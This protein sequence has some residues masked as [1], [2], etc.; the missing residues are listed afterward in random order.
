[1]EGLSQNLILLGLL[2]LIGVSA[3]IIGRRTA[4]PRVSILL[5]AGCA[6]GPTGLDLVPELQARWF[7]WVTNI[8]LLMVGFL[9]G[10]QL[11]RASLR[12]HG[13]VV[14]GVSLSVV[15]I[16]AAV[17]LVGL[18]ALGFPLEL[19][20]LLAAVAPAT[21]PAAT[22]DVVHETKTKGA[23]SESL[24]GIVAIDDAWG[25]I[26]FSLML[27][28]LALLAGSAGAEQS[29]A[30][31]LWEVGGAV[32]LGGL[33]GLPMAFITGR[34]RPGEPTQAEALGIVL[35]CG[36][37]ALWLDVSFLLSAMV[38]GASVANFARHHRR[39][40]HA[41]EGI[42]WPFMILFFLLAGASLDI[43]SL[44]G[45]GLLGSAY[46][47]LRVLGRLLGGWTGAWLSGAPA[48]WRPWVGT[49]LL[50]QAGVALG[51]ALIAAQRYPEYSHALLSVV[52]AA[53][54]L[55]EILGPVGTRWALVNIGDDHHGRDVKPLNE[56]NE[57][58]R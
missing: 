33:L 44:A 39:P 5:L 52:I 8:A 43:G 46:I 41:V 56:T 26:L 10:G 31:G 53:T 49:A 22:A 42:E 18:L 47:V 35:L 2:F 38:L 17:M 27:S 24:L 11:T 4:L 13:R 9:L 45:I 6:I 28:G 50:P 55:F 36:G 21:D 1:M 23:F 37:L 51:M 57:I 25:L 34:I 32:L 58:E 40:F 30:D 14:L 29:L 15:V 3:D 7:P 54:V 48:S 12:H 19:A 20:V 16:T